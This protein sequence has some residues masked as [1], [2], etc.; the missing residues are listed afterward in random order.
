MSESNGGVKW[1]TIHVVAVVVVPMVV[2]AAGYGALFA[3]VSYIAT[4]VSVYETNQ[5]RMQQSINQLN[6]SIAT[7]AESVTELSNTRAKQD[8]DGKR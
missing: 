3:Q 5:D 8:Q 6:V 7:L 1:S 4:R 2:F